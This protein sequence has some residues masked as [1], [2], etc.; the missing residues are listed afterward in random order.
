MIISVA[1]VPVAAGLGA[2]EFFRGGVSFCTVARAGRAE[3]RRV[4]G[5]RSAEA[6][7][8]LREPLEQLEAL[9]ARA[10]EA[11]ADLLEVVHVSARRWSWSSVC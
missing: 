7:V 3:Q 11:D 6:I 2:G 10:T 8:V 5:G 1:R 9:L 4:A